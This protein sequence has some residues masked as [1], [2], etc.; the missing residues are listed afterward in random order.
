MRIAAKKNKGVGFIIAQQHVVARLIK[1][2]IVMLKQQRFRLG[3]GNVNLGNKRHQRFGFTRSQV[4]AKI[5]AKP[6]FQI[7]CFAYIDNSTA[8]IIHTIDARLAGYGFQ[9]SFC[10][11]N[12][13]H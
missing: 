2:N 1:L 11:K 10:I 5:A 6:L 3:D 4:A 9:E 13:I 12:I 8:S 7:F